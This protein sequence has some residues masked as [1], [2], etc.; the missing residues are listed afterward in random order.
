M[1][2]KLKPIPDA[3]PPVRV[4]LDWRAYFAEFSRAHGDNP[5]EHEGRLLWQDGWRYSSIS[6][7]GPEYPPPAD[8]EEL[9]RLQRAYWQRRMELVEEQ[10][11]RLQR[12]MLDLEAGQSIRGVPL[13]HRVVG[14]DEN[15]RLGLTVAP[16]K[17]EA[18]KARHDWLREDVAQC[19]RKLEELK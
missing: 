12:T 17:L 19:H 6:H 2:L 8:A 4:R 13:M 15:G 9:R 1:K 16:L 7:E 14:E 18:F 11:G 10:R 3:L 5:V